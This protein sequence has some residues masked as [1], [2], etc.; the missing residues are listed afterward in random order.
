MKKIVCLLIIVLVYSCHKKK[1]IEKNLSLIPYIISAEDRKLKEYTDSLNLYRAETIVLPRKGFYGESNLIIDKKGE[2]YYYQKRYIQIICNYGTEND[3]LP[4]FL[5][6]Q[7][8]DLIKIPIE[9]LEKIV[10]ENVMKKPNNRR[11]LIIASEKDTIKVKGFLKF[12]Y[13][14]KVPTYF[15][16]RTTQE[17]DTVLHYKRTDKYYYSNKI[18]W[19][20]SKIKFRD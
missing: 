17:E 20:K 12:Y 1:N 11:I 5:D 9:S 7:P 13:N 14:L 2:I 15:I 6:L 8:K 4:Q 3:T 18:K 16:R 19:D 10:N